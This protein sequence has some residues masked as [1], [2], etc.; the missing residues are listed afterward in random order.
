MFCTIEQY[1][2]GV[3]PVPTKTRFGFISSSSGDFSQHLLSIANLSIQASKSP[4][5]KL[6]HMTR[7]RL[8]GRNP[9]NFLERRMW[10]ANADKSESTTTLPLRPRGPAKRGP[11]RL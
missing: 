1:E 4:D 5:A 11:S 2:S 7:S 6:G 8:F 10:I 9:A 3:K